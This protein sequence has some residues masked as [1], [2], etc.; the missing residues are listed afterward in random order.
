MVKYGYIYKVYLSRQTDGPEGLSCI[1]IKSPGSASV[2]LFFQWMSDPGSPSVLC[3]SFRRGKPGL[4]I[5]SKLM[6]WV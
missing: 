5:P 1:L 4:K 2:G 3:E 6:S